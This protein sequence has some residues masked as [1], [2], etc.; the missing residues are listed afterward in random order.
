MTPLEAVAAELRVLKSVTN[1]CIVSDN[2]FIGHRAVSFDYAVLT[3]RHR[4]RVFTVAVGFQE[5]AYPEYP[6]HFIYVADLEAPNIRVHS[7]F[8]HAGRKWSA[9]SVPPSDFWDGLAST[10]KNMKIYIARHLGR[11]WSQV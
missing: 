10:K 8:H 4:N 1:V 6:P 5:D 3:G 7:S 11:F 2:G 9:F